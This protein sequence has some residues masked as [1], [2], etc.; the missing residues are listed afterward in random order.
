MTHNN[1]GMDF[2]YDVNSIALQTPS[3][4]AYETPQET[5]DETSHETSMKH[6]MKQLKK[7]P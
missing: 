3:C 1:L 5:S 2:Y 6:P 7:K 4:R